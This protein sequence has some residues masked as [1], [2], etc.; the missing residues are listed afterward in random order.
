MQENNL[1]V[2]NRPI[3][4]LKKK[5]INS[6][7]KPVIGKFTN[8]KLLDHFADVHERLTDIEHK[9]NPTSKKISSNRS[10]QM[11]ILHHLG[12]L[13]ILS[14]FK[15]S[16]KKKAKLL[17]ILLNASPDNIENDLSSIH[18]PNSKLKTVTNYTLIN[19]A[20]SKA[21]I[22]IISDSTAKILK[23]LQEKEK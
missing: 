18:N 13:D 17:S 22:K 20:F 21:D 7:Y 23:N 1:L 19:D 4:K 2:D 12:V 16:N 3:H 8:S 6:P 5:I 14:E 9:I 11:L 10:Q 15:I